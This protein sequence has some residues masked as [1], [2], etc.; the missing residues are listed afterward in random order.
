MATL[1]LHRVTTLEE[2]EPL[3]HIA[4][5]AW[6]DDPLFNWFFPGGHEHPEDLIA[7]WKC[8]LQVEFYDPGKF[9]LAARL[10]DPEDDGSLPG[11]V[12]GFAV[13][14]RKGASHA[15]RSWR[16]TSFSR[17]MFMWAKQD[18]NLGLKR[19]KLTFTNAYAFL[20]ST[21]KRSAVISRVK[22]LEKEMKSVRARQPADCWYLC[23]L[24]VSSKAQKRGVGRKLLNW[25][26]ERSEEEGVPAGL[27]ASNAGLGLYYSAGFEQTGWMFYDDG[28]QKQTVM[29][30]K[31]RRSPLLCG[32]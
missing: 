17:N 6:R 18:I 12:V 27:E 29:T 2:L 9:V 24:G 28:K 14:E 16:G 13:W 23:Y 5:D 21:P 3:Y 31:C 10:Q 11:K 26:I 7:L 19:S 22:A 15:A 30:R 25:G 20:F 32:E 8:I 1:T 4:A